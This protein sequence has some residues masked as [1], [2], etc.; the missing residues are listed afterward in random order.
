MDTT[1]NAYS[2]Q[3]VIV[4]ERVASVHDA[5]FAEHEYGGWLELNVGEDDYAWT[6]TQEADNG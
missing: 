1:R 6:F 5:L 3:D 4:D 2:E